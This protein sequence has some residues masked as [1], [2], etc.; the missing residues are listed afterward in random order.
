MTHP[1]FS[2]VAAPRVLAHRGF[3]PA[4][5][6]GVAENSVAALAAARA[7]G[8][9]YLE[10]DCHLT[11]DGT[12]V[13]FHD[14]D[15]VRV[16]GDPRRV[17]E[18]S[19]RELTEIMS[20][21]GGLATLSDALDAF[22]DAR[23]NLD[24]KASPAAA[25]VGLL[26]ARE[27]H[28]VLVTSFSDARRAE[29]LASA[30]SKGGDPATSAGMGTLLRLLAAARSGLRRTASRLV[31][32]VDALQVPERYRGLRVVTPRLIDIAHSAGVE[33]HVWTVNDAADMRRLLALG[34]DGIVSDRADVAL[35]V[36]AGRV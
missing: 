20:T 28:R 4:D 34:V 18:V 2:G 19:T 32:D 14:D 6:E 12:V 36:A 16:A 1:W 33:V 22:P 30:R 5:A 27:S 11:A 25:S 35:A 8:T 21:R 15:L 10:S 29:A 3:V 9:V 17:S 24:V 26:V 23:F 13:L 7:A 31:A